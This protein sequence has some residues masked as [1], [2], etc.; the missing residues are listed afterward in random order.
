MSEITTV[1]IENV[2]KSVLP[3]NTFISVRE[4]K[5]LGIEYIAIAFAASDY[6]I[7]GVLGQKPQIVSL[8]LDLETLELHPQIFGGNGGQCIYRKPNLN[9]PKEKYLAMKGVKIPFKRPK[10]EERF[11]LA[12]IERFAKNWVIALKENKDVL[13]YQDIVNYDEFLR[14]F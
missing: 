8:N 12:A 14:G 9:D 13:Q 5:C 2:L 3:A 1:N 7:N 6:D 11:I 4:R 10:S